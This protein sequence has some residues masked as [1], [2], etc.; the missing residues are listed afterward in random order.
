MDEKKHID[1]I[2]VMY[3]T[4]LSGDIHTRVEHLG[5][6]ISVCKQWNEKYMIEKTLGDTTILERRLDSV[7][8]GIANYLGVLKSMK[9][10]PPKE[11]TVFSDV[12]AEYNKVKGFLTG[13]HTPE[14]Q[15]HLVE[16]VLN[17][18]ELRMASKYYLWAQQGYVGWL[19]GAESGASACYQNTQN[20]MNSLNNFLFRN[21]II[22]VTADSLFNN[23]PIYSNHSKGGK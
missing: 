8:F 2:T 9:I 19:S 3:A 23:S 5:N 13:M 12:V 20:C 14:E 16:C 15:R 1:L 7:V 17:R 6:L 4:C 10:P 21:D 11:N 22:K 18:K